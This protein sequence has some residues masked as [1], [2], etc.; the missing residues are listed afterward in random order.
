VY[1]PATIDI[2]DLTFGVTTL[3]EINAQ[4]IQA[5]GDICAALSVAGADFKVVDCNEAPVAVNDLFSTTTTTSISFNPL[6]NDLDSEMESLT[7]CDYILPTNGTISVTA[8]S[9]TYTP[10]AGFVGIETIQ[11][12]ACDEFGNYGQATITIMVQGGD[13]ANPI[14]SV[15]TLPL[16]TTL[17]CP[18]FCQLGEEYTVTDIQHSFNANITIQGKCISYT[19]LPGFTGFEQIIITACNNGQC[20]SATVLLTVSA[21]CDAEPNQAPVVANDLVSTEQGT[22][23][24][25]NLLSN[26]SDPEGSTL[27]IQTVGTAGQGVVTQTDGGVTYTPNAGFIGLDQFTY[28]AC[29]PFGLCTAGVVSV[30]VNNPLSGSAEDSADCTPDPICTPVMTTT[31]ICVDFCNITDAEVISVGTVFSCSIQNI[32]QN[33]FTYTGLPAFSGEEL[34]TVEGCNE[35]GACETVVIALTVGDCNL[36]GFIQD[37]GITIGKT[38]VED[39]EIL[40]LANATN[41]GFGAGQILS[42]QNVEHCFEMEHLTLHVYNLSGALVHQANNTAALD[43]NGT[44]NGAATPS[45]IY[46]FGLMSQNRLIA[47][48]QLVK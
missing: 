45:G 14:L 30:Q 5:G 20:D 24:F 34:L 10:N 38:S 6:Q 18:E 31:S 23:I 41:M 29:D 17:V 28:T 39:C 35:N 48:G 21:N 3:Y 47:S 13:C 44:A 26:D 8:T 22:E 19:S 15:C 43:W 25:I 9:M 27:T 37:D 32:Q 36:D 33:C 42:F 11:Y 1:N 12:N 2:T 4:L 7:I 16:E 46:V 40:V